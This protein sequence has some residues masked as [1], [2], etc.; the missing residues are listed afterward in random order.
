MFTSCEEYTILTGK[1]PYSNKTISTCAEEILN[2]I[3][4]YGLTT[5]IWT[6]IKV[7][8]NEDFN[9]YPTIPTARYGHSGSYVALNDPNNYYPGTNK[10]V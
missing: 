1:D 10:P 4:I 2:D 8:T 6:Y 9:L 3:W 5:G 7:G